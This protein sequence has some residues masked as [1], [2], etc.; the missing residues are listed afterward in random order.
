MYVSIGGEFTSSRVF[1]ILTLMYL[2]I[3]L[4]IDFNRAVIG[5]AELRVVTN[6][7]QCILTKGTIRSNVHTFRLENVDSKIKVDNLSSGL[8][9][10]SNILETVL[11]NVSFEMK[12]GE[13]IAVIGRVGSGKSSLLLS[14]MNELEI[15]EGRVQLNGSVAYVPQESWILPTIV[16][17]N[18]IYGRGL[19]ERWYQQVVSACCLDTD[20]QQFVEGDL[21][22]VGDRGV[23]LSGGQKARITLARAIYRNSDIYLLDDPYSAVDTGIARRLFSLFTTG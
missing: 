20:M 7:V 2:Y 22:E 8:L 13:K 4:F 21:T 23:T 1:G 6:R 19:D 9:T 14:L 18:I 15:V 16:R 10:E 3:R 17:E 5:I 12:R 11:T